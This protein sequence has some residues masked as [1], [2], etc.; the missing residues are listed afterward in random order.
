MTKSKRLGD[1]PHSP[2]Q[3]R[4]APLVNGP[5]AETHECPIIMARRAACF[6]YQA[7]FEDENAGWV[8]DRNA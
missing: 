8:H 4:F 3:C 6:R 7:L 1:R 5:S 2:G